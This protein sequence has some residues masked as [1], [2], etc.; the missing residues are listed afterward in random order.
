LAVSI[1]CCSVCSTRARF[2][3]CDASACAVSAMAAEVCAMHP[4]A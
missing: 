3:R 1:F 2:R 4:G